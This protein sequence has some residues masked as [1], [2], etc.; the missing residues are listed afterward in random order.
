MESISGLIEYT[1]ILLDLPEL[2]IELLQF[3]INSGNHGCVL[4]VLSLILEGNML[5]SLVNWWEAL[6]RS[7]IPWITLFAP[8]LNSISFLIE[9]GNADDRIVLDVDAPCISLGDICVTTV[10]LLICPYKVSLHIRIFVLK[11]Q[12]F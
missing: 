3:C 11:L 1:V 6:G 7:S 8:L 12:K 10:V 9:H 4:K 2:L 5:I